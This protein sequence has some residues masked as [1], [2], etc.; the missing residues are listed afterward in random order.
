[1]FIIEGGFSIGIASRLFWIL[2]GLTI[3]L[4]QLGFF[5]IRHIFRKININ[6]YNNQREIAQYQRQLN[7]IKQTEENDDSSILSN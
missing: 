1:M 5:S 6:N 2:I 7:Y 4:F 3:F